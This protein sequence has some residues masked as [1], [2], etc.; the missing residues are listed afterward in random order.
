MLDWLGWVATSMLA[1]FGNLYTALRHPAAWLDLSDKEAVMRLIYYGASEELFFVL[2]TA[3]VIVTA[4]GLW[5]HAILWAVVRGLE[6]FA[7]FTGRTVAWAGLIMVLQQI[8]IIFLQRIFRVSQ[9]ELAPFGYGFAKDLSWWSE[10]LKLYNAMI[11]AL[12]V[13][14]TFVQGGHVRVDLFYANA[15]YH[16][17]KLID[18]LGSLFFMLPVAVLTWI[19]AWFFFWRIMIVPNTSATDTLDKL[20]LKSKAMRWNVETISFSPNGFDAYFLFK[21][22]ILAFVAM[23]FLQGIAFFYRNLLEYVEGPKSEGKYLDKD[24]LEQSGGAKPV[25][26]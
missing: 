12:C 6:G 17:K 13:S 22:L 7:N 14:Y 11:V 19:Y 10:E 3:F 9:I 23:S 5:R 18:M 20:L 16:R 26:Q 21:V 1:S 24:V 2:L 4:L 15:R 8:V 25:A